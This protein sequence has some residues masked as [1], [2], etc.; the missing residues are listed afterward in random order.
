MCMRKFSLLILCTALLS[1]FAAAQD[2][3]VGF[4][5]GPSL[6]L[7]RNR[8]GVGSLQIAPDDALSWNREVFVRKLSNRW[9]YEG[10]VTH[11]RQRYE[12]DTRNE[13][14]EVQ[15]SY[16]TNFVEANFLVQYDVTNPYIPYLMPQLRNMRS[17]LG[18]GIIPRVSFSDVT[19]SRSLGPAERTME[20]TSKND[21]SLF[22]G[23]SY[24]SLIPL[25]KRWSLSSN[26]SYKFQP[27]DQYLRERGNFYNPNRQI[28]WM[29]GLCY[30]L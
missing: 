12:I 24:T 28:S 7:T 18:F 16:N 27:F 6:W 10:G 30:R 17:F 21:V 23:V 1:N 4:R 3:L 19:I 15:T 5:Q 13:G 11:Y 26:I 25:S 29:T 14:A 20:T 8:L 9:A 22:F 2:W